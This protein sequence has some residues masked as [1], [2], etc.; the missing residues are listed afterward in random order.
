[1]GYG[2][3]DVVRSMRVAKEKGGYLS[4][5]LLT[6]PGVTDREEEAERLCRLVAEAGADQV[7]TRSLAIDP[8]V[9]MAVARGRGGR[10]PAIGIP[11]LLR[12]LK[13]ARPGLVIGNFSRAKGERGSEPARARQRKAAAVQGRTR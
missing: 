2:L 12:E 8:D 11:A 5:N 6:F 1:V 10:G 3:P 9:Y 7:Q 13:R 4:L